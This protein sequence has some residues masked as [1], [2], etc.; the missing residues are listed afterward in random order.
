LFVSFLIILTLAKNNATTLKKYDG[1]LNIFQNDADN[2]I[3][4]NNVYMIYL[5]KHCMK[6]L[7]SLLLFYIFLFLGWVFTSRQHNMNRPYGDISALLDEEDISCSSGYFTGK[8]GHLSRA[9]DVP[10]ARST[11]FLHA[12]VQ[13]PWRDSNRKW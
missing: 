13:S 7:F 11:S 4:S 12:K 2:T 10:L 6:K 8:S 1:H 9:T 5:R 3:A